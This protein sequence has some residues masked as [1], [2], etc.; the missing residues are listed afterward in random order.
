[1]SS[2]FD[3]PNPYSSPI[4]G[5]NFGGS[6]Q[7]SSNIKVT[8]PAVFLIVTG[9]LGLLFSIYS[10]FAAVFLDPP[11][12]DPNMPEAMRA[13]QEGA[14]G[15]VAAV[16]QSIF[17]F[18]NIAI[19]AGGVMMTQQKN[20]VFALIACILAIVNFGNCCC[21]LGIPIGIWG[22]VVLSMA[23]VKQAFEARR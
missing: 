2:G 3:S 5:N 21:I 18:V 23:D 7:P 16:I 19:I 4:P 22:I 8:L 20:W 12:L 9:T 14:H 10:A 17:I 13:F 11:A 15:P 6:P 1:M